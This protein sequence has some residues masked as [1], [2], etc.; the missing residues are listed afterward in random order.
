VVERPTRQQ[1]GEAFLPY[2]QP[3]YTLFQGP[4]KKYC[5][6]EFLFYMV[7]LLFKQRFITCQAINTVKDNLKEDCNENKRPTWPR[8]RD[9]ASD[10]PPKK[11]LGV[12]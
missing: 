2:A 1:P 9:R 11:P 8:F 4:W 3:T 10:P 7:H 6:R 5:P 12:C